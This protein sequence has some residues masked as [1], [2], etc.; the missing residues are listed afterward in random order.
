MSDN[1]KKG[2]VTC[3]YCSQTFKG[4]DA[5]RKHLDD[6]WAECIKCNWDERKKLP[7]W[8]RDEDKKRGN[9]YFSDMRQTDFE[10]H[11]RNKLMLK[12]GS[13]SKRMNKSKKR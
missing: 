5:F 13:R 4:Y 11:L 9:W 8:L 1:V 7:Q 2:Q 6:G 12:R 3:H 10:A